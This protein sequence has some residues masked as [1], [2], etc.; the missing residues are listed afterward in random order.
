MHCTERRPST[1]V[2]P[3]PC[4]PLP[5]PDASPVQ[6]IL[7]DLQDAV[8]ANTQP[9]CVWDAYLRA[10]HVSGLYRPESLLR[11]SLDLAMSWAHGQGETGPALVRFGWACL[12]DSLCAR[13]L[14]AA[15]VIGH[16]DWAP[17]LVDGQPDPDWTAAVQRAKYVG[18]LTP[19]A[20]ATK[21]W[22]G[23]VQPSSI[24]PAPPLKLTATPSAS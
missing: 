5:A 18:P 2:A 23:R 15:D 12:R 11:G 7:L 9:S 10:C 19:S 20:R 4:A 22:G 1:G 21:P 13:G 6:Q 16:R 3:P 14:A 17:P 8:A 24:S